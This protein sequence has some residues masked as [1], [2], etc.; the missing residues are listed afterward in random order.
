MSQQPAIGHHFE[1]LEQEHEANKLGMWTFLATEVLFFGGIFLCYFAYRYL[2]A[3]AFTE[4]SHQLYASIG[5]L[6]TVV[7]LTSS[8]TMALAVHAIQ[9][10]QRRAVTLLL[11]ATAGLGALFLAI[12]A[13]E[14]YLDFREHL[15]PGWNYAPEGLTHAGQAEL[16]FLLYFIMTG[17]HAL[18]LTIGITIVTLVAWRVWRGHFS[19]QHYNGIENTGLYW[20]FVD[21]VWVFLYPMLYLVGHLGGG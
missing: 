13:F 18:H 3:Q 4:A 1:T 10:N 6:N 20:H 21:V 19:A 5:T 17:I 9:Q 8:L 15:V 2:Y 16:F 7:L 12:K 14:Y 11:L